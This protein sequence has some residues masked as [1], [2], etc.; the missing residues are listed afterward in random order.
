MSKQLVTTALALALW[1]SAASAQGLN[2]SW[3]DCGAAGQPNKMFACNVNSGNASMYASYIPPSGV[4]QLVGIAS[5]I[6]LYT[7]Q[8]VLPDWWKFGSSFCRGSGALS[9]V[10]DFTAGPTT[11]KDVWLGQALAGFLYDVGYGTPARARLEVQVAIP[12]DFAV[13]VDPTK[14]YYAYAVRLQ[15]TKS[16]GTGSC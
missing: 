1:A 5:Q 10:T 8:A 2:L 9:I 15:Y 3:D 12:V 7:D 6:D 13:A 14:E 11:C 16:T 4:N